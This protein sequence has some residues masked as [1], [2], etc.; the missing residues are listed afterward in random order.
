M[1]K[2]LVISY[3]F[4][5]S[6]VKAVLVN[7]KLD[8]LAMSIAEYS[9]ITPKVGWAE[10]DTDEYWRAIICAT[11]DVIKTSHE[12]KNDV[13]AL[14]F[15]TQ[16]MGVIPIDKENN[17]LYNNISWVDGRAE[18]QAAEINNTLS[19]DVFCG[20]DVVPKLLWIKEERPDVY[21]K[22][23]FFMDVNSFLKYKATGNIVFEMTGASSYCIDLQKQN[24]NTVVLEAAGIDTSKLPS[25]VNSFD[26]VGNLTKQ[27]AAELDLN[28]DTMVFGGCDDVQAATIGSAAIDE[29]EGHIYLG[30]SAWLCVSTAS[31]PEPRNGAVISKS[32]DPNKN[33]VIGVTQSAGM[34]IDWGLNNF[35]KQE[36]A[37]ESISEYDVLA[38][39]ERNIRPGS[40]NLIITPW[41]YGEY[42]PITSEDVRTT[43]FNLTNMHTR[44][45]VLK[46]IKEGIA[47]N[48]RWTYENYIKDYGFELESVKVVGGGALSSA[49]MQLMADILQI[50]LQITYD[51]RHA[52]AR[53]AAVCAYVGS[54]IYKDFEY[55]KEMIKVH[56]EY[57]PNKDNKEI[58]NKLFYE[59][60]QL[61]YSLKESYERINH[62]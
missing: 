55:A 19:A 34:T 50:K 1:S 7:K 48:L 31:I 49:W 16:A 26:K 15:S 40:D 11:H 56:K 51:M 42:C 57:T 41:M 14:V 2:E 4:G 18:K 21:N 32:A 9:M 58:Y 46:A 39:E 36:R 29:G 27:A 43:M 24:W 47:Y 6:G 33:L 5:T 23:K 20:K 12:D 54:G 37:D 17:I 22:T 44:A 8:I 61:Y 10:Q 45:H 53:G 38:E 52:G 30:S 35:Y 3:D 59:Y 25:I 60:K 62:L 13:I 28:E